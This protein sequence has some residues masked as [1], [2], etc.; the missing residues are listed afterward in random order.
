[1]HDGKLKPSDLNGD[2]LTTILGDLK[3]S[4]KTGYGDSFLDYTANA[5]SKLQLKQNL[6]RF[7]GAKTFQELA[8]I[9]YFLGNNKSFPDFKKEALKVN[10]EYNVQYLE[11]EFVTANRSGAMAEKWQK[12]ND[13]KVLYPNLKYKTVK[14]NRVREEHR[15]LHDVIKPIDDAFWDKWYPP[16]GWRCRCYVT[17]TDEPATPGT[18]T[19]EPTPGFH[20]HVGKSNMTFN[21]EEHPYFIFPAADAKKIKASF[22][23]LKLAEPDYNLVHTNKKAELEVSTWAD[24]YDIE[25]NHKYAKTLVDELGVSVKIKA[26]SEFIKDRKN[27][28]YE[29]NGLNS[30]LKSIQSVKGITNGFDAAKTQM[31]IGKN[32]YSVV[33]NLDNLK[34][35]KLADIT[36]Q[37]SNK[38]SATRGKNIDR[39]FFIRKGKA[40]ELTRDN[41]LKKEYKALEAML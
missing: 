34:K 37:L 28:E 2:L 15:Q 21:E 18:A 17:Q 39:V 11:N 36:K 14:D 23:N 12:I 22:E 29:I 1:M 4:M 9:N 32:H 16:N 33:F 30:D 25:I 5:K 6:Y 41:I 7:S 3:G 13:Q 24:P 27:P 38:F 35:V 20:G 40:V 8:K 31:G 26:H 19:G 10:Q